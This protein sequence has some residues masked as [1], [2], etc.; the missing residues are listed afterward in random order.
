MTANSFFEMK[1]PHWRLK[2][3][4]ESKASSICWSYESKIKAHS[5]HL[6][7][8]TS[9][10]L[11]QQGGVSSNTE[12]VFVAQTPTNARNLRIKHQTAAQQQQS[13]VTWLAHLEEVVFHTEILTGESKDFELFLTPAIQWGRLGEDWDR[14]RGL[15][16]RGHTTDSY[17]PWASHLNQH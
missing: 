9:H 5:T 7:L 16:C 2:Q 6:S 1:G 13:Y 10:S 11:D 15:H 4:C 17:S 14:R 12:L 3:S 8:N